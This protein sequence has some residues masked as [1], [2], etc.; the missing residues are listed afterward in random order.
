VLD[1]AVSGDQR[2]Q[3]S[4]FTEAE[5]ALAREV[6]RLSRDWGLKPYQASL[7]WLLSR[8]AVASTIV[9]AETPEELHTNATAADIKLEPA[10]LDALTAL[11]SEPQRSI[12]APAMNRNRH[13]PRPTRRQSAEAF[14]LA[15]AREP[16]KPLIPTAVGS[17]LDCVAQ[18]SSSSP[19]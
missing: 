8:P 16:V 3:G 11:A 12:T 13:P 14:N 19:S 17:S 5:I 10:Q 1:R 4:G 6:D 7:A 9:G 15:T 2:F 18:P